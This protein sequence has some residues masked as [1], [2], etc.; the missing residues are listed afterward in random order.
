MTLL[1]AECT[2]QLMPNQLMHSNTTII[3]SCFVSVLLLKKETREQSGFY[4][5]TNYLERLLK[6]KEKNKKQFHDIATKV[7]LIFFPHLRGIINPFPALKGIRASPLQCIHI[8]EGHTKAVLCVDS[9]DDLLF[10]GSKGASSCVMWIFNI[11][12]FND[13]ILTCF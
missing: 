1:F 4:Y 11:F 3:I 9:T 7:N 6:A 13:Y 10:T 5:N 12:F 2:C 8:A